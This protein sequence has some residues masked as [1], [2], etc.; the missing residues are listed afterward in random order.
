MALAV[1]QTFRKF[2]QMTRLGLQISPAMKDKLKA[3]ANS[4]D[5]GMSDFARRALRQYLE[6][7]EK[8][9]RLNDEAAEYPINKR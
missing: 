9:T 4:D 5:A 3:L 7:Y 1:G 6:R 2:E 8:A